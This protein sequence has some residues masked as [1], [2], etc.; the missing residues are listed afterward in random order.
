MVEE[1]WKLVIDAQDHQQA[2]A[3]APGGTPSVCQFPSSPS[4]KIDLQTQEAVSIGFCLMLVY[5][6]SDIDYTPK[7]TYLTL[8]IT[9]T[10]GRLA[11]QVHRK[12]VSSY[13]FHSQSQTGLQIQVQ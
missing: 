11:D 12:V 10:G 2:L 7:Y 3:G 13:Q 5:Q 4:L 6:I 1:A 8:M 9:P